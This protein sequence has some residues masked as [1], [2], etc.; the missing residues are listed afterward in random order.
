MDIFDASNFY[1]NNLEFVDTTPLNDAFN[2]FGI[3]D[4]ITLI[5][6]GSYTVL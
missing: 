3:Q 6:S 1:Q 4:K 5:L 2:Y